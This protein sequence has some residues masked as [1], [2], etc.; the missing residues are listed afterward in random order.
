MLRSFILSLTLV[1]A[2]SV[3]AFANN[4][5]DD[6]I[7]LRSYVE[8]LMTESHE[9][10]HNKSLSEEQMKQQVS[11]LLRANLHLNWMAKQ[12]LGRNIKSVSKE[13]LK[14]FTKVYAEFV[15]HS[16]SNLVKSYKGEKGRLI[17]IHRISNNLFMV[18]TEILSPNDGT[19]TEVKYLVH[20]LTNKGNI[21]FL[22]GDIITEGVSLLD[23]QRSEF[24]QILSNKGIE[25][26]INDIQQKQ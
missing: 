19:H 26:L 4:S 2:F 15:I 10:L 18:D 11:T 17:R 23:S 8:N 25:G 5:P 1:I 6:Q 20:E 24:N 16:Y 7:A 3:S 22:V 14:N 21:R 9:L 12:S 13:Q